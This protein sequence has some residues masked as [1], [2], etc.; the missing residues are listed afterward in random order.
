MGAAIFEE[1][2]PGRRLRADLDPFVYQSPPMLIEAVALIEV[3]A[4]FADPIPLFMAAVLMP[5]KFVSAEPSN[6]TSPVVTTPGVSWWPPALTLTLVT[7][8]A[9]SVSVNT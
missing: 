1:R 6:S 8:E 7:V 5:A 9:N 2:E 4:W 3:T